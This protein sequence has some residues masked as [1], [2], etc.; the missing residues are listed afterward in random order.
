MARARANENAAI[1]NIDREMRISRE[2]KALLD[3][4]AEIN[5]KIVVLVETR[6]RLQTELERVK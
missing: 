4:I 2:R 3:E 6:Q 5:K 1:R